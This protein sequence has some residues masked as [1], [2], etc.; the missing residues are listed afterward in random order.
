M[1]AIEEMSQ[2][3]SSVNTEN[4]PPI[5]RHSSNLDAFLSRTKQA[6]ANS[7]RMLDALPEAKDS[8]SQESS[9]SANLTSD[10]SSDDDSSSDDGG[11]MTKTEEYL[12]KKNQM[13]QKG[14]TF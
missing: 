11:K 6:F 4:Y 2:S 7:S 13:G 3:C 8:D 12:K 10:D 5:E 1:D 14:A 9:E